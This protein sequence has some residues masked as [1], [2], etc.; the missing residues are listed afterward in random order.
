MDSRVKYPRT[1]HLPWSLGA[2]ND[3]RMLRNDDL[4]DMFGG[5]QVVVT[6]KMDGENTT[7]YS[8][9]TSHARS[10]DSPGAEWRTWIRALASQLAGEIPAGWRVCG[11]NVYAQHAL[12]YDRLPAYFLVFGIYDTRNVCL[13]WP[14]TLEWCELLGL[15]TVPVLY[16]GVWDPVEVR[17]C[18]DRT[19]DAAGRAPSAFG[20]EAEGYVVRIKHAFHYEDFGRSVAKYVRKDHVPTDDHWMHQA[21]VP[22]KLE[23]P[24]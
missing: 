13:S 22:N 11:E 19:R 7:I 6:E 14:E 18:S 4:S 5:R 21:I 1:P 2:T 20:N 15:H 10:L 23:K 12:H 17:W 16:T 24:A 3:D 9:G 8:D